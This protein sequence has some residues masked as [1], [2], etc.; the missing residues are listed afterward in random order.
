M[1]TS[2][3]NFKIGSSYTFNIYPYSV[4]PSTFTNVTCTGIFSASTASKF[5]DIQA[6]HARVYPL[7]PKGTPNSPTGYTYAQFEL[8]SGTT[9]ILGIPWINMDT[10]VENTNTEIVVTISNKTVS[11]IP[12]IRDILLSNGIDKLTIT[13]K[14]INQ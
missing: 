7:L 5:L 4:L 14:S 9:Q 10:L 13:S 6:M 8:P 2:S 1:P 11:D 12:T 3:D